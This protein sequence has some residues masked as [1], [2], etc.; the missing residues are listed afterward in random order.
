[1]RKSDCMA[2]PAYRGDTRGKCWYRSE[3]K[4]VFPLSS[5]YLTMDNRSLPS[6]SPLL[7]VCV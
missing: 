4:S 7:G 6:R 2:W 5:Y 1:M 3:G